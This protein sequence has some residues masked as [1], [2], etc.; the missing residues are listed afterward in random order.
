MTPLQ[1]LRARTQIQEVVMRELSVSTSQL[2]SKN[3]TYSSLTYSIQ[4]PL[5]PMK[6][7]KIMLFQPNHHPINLLRPN[8]LYHYTITSFIK[9]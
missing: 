1:K 3:L 5:P 8:S 9:L 4:I 2:M 7:L 6:S